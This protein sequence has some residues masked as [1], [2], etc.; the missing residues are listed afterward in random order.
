MSIKM[1]D[2]LLHCKGNISFA[3]TVDFWSDWLA[4]V[5]YDCEVQGGLD[6]FSCDVVLVFF[7]SISV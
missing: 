3:I 5:R 4:L 6:I 7:F 1:T 2:F